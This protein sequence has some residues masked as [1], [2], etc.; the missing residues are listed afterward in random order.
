[1]WTLRCVVAVFVAFPEGRY[2]IRWKLLKHPLNNEPHFLSNSCELNCLLLQVNH[3]D[4]DTKSYRSKFE[5]SGWCLKKILINENIA[6][7]KGQISKVE[8]LRL[9]GG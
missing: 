2:Y 9:N 3:I 4:F 8:D 6:L 5:N 1:M 7:P